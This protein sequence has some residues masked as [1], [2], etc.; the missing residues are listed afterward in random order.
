M[1]FPRQVGLEIETESHGLM[2][3]RFQGTDASCVLAVVWSQLLPHGNRLYLPHHSTN[4]LPVIEEESQFFEETCKTL[5]RQYGVVVVRL[6]VKPSE[7]ENIRAAME[8]D[9]KWIGKPL[10][11]CGKIGLYSGAGLPWSKPVMQLRS[12]PGFQR[13]FELCLK[14]CERFQS[15]YPYVIVNESVFLTERKS[16]TFKGLKTHKDNKVVPGA[17]EIGYL[18]GALYITSSSS[19]YD[20]FGALGAIIAATP[21]VSTDIL[22]AAA[23]RAAL[24]ESALVSRGPKDR[25]VPKRVLGGDHMGVAAAKKAPKADLHSYIQTHCETHI[26]EYIKAL[27]STPAAT[28]SAATRDRTEFVKE[29]FGRPITSTA[30]LEKAL[31][32]GSLSLRGTLIRAIDGGL[33]SSDLW[34]CKQGGPVRIACDVYAEAKRSNDNQV[35]SLWVSNSGQKKRVQDLTWKQ[36]LRGSGK[37]VKV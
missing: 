37:K 20:R 12:I 28:V 7:L 1:D 31:K 29:H 16:S 27:P 30:A 9:K 15:R 8:E 34:S 11:P 26:R 18:Q 25:P 14:A 36:P 23:G 2:S 4:N 35:L 22:V 10:G 32:D 24:T 19:K 5:F 33:S 17:P 13:T 3:A 6:K 21:E